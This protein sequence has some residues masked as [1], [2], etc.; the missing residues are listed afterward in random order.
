MMETLQATPLEAPV[1]RPPR[2]SRRQARTD[3]APV[4]LGLDLSLRATGMVA[5]P[6]DWGQ[7]WSRVSVAEVG[8][9]LPKDAGPAERVER[10]VTIRNAVLEFA[11]EHRV[12]QAWIEQYA[13][14]AIKSQAHSLGELG[15][16]VMV[17]LHQL[18]VALHV[19]PPASARQLLGKAPRKDAKQWAAARLRD[20]GAPHTWTGDQLDAFAVANWGLAEL[21]GS[22]VVMRGVAG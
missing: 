7:D 17:S 6:L 8:H 20:A 16:I 12:H 2:R 5:V 1:T 19:V 13:F 4:V 14:T 22:A 9:G 11:H 18:G 15:G 21:G 3:E 10:L